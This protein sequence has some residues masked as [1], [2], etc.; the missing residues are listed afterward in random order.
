MNQSKLMTLPAKVIVLLLAMSFYGHACAQDDK[1]WEKYI[2]QMG[3]EEDIDNGRLEMLYDDLS[4]LAESKLDINTCS[5]EDLEQLPFLTKQQVMD[6]IEYRDKAKRLETPMELYLVPSLDR[7]TINLLQQFITFSPAMPSDTI[8][9]LRN[10][11]KHGK[12]ELV[13]DFN[14]P[15][16]DRKGD[17]NGYLGYKY[18]HWLRYTFNYGQRVKA[19]FTA[20]QDAGEPFFAGKNPAGYDFYSAYILLRDMRRLKALAIGR[21]RLRF[22]MGLVMN[23]SVGFGKLASLSNIWNSVNHVFGHSSRSEAKYLQGAAATIN[24]ANGLD[25]TPFVSYRKIDATLNK[26]STTVA[27]ILETGYHRT[28]SEMARR[29]NTAE[30]LAGG[31]INYFNSGFHIGATGFYSSFNRTL[32]MDNGQ[33]YRHW[34]P[35]GSSF[36]NLSV[37]YGYTSNKLNISGETATDNR[38]SVATINTISYQLNSALTMMALQRYYPYQY[39]SL[40]S[41]SFAEGGQANDESGIFVGG[42]WL[43]WHNASLM[44]YTDI[45]YFAWPKYGV[46]QSSHRWDNF[47]QL[48]YAAGKWAFLLRYRL[49]MKEVDNDGSNR[50][51]KQYNHRGRITASYSNDTWSLKTQ[52]DI[53]CCKDIANSFGYML[54]E[55]ASWKWRWF[56]A[57]ASVG[58]FH[59]D[60]YSSRVYT[61]EPGMLYNFYFHAF[62][63]HG[64]RSTL[65]ARA[66]ISDS[67]IV[68]AKLGSTHYF[69]RAQISSGL[70]QID[71]STQTDLEL[72]VKWK[73]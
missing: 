71:S 42:K 15:F 57:R 62:S 43:P 12:N 37:D 4:E 22:G 52:A 23:T 24:V 7:Q 39:F 9:S 11:L 31:N 3:E 53:S 70:Q 8:P 19:G 63:G 26:D 73:F 18:K 67:L 29:R 13:A 46:S 21:Y 1:T 69:D 30:T 17:K 45:S 72:Q 60:D 36:W 34:Y 54:S 68:I 65:N 58:Y 28:Q 10:V 48:D 49:K 59:T 44:F 20:S 56:Y 40:H 5:R 55:N 25:I 66:T 64:M 47:A 32:K 38:N 27:T 16:Y 51:I 33:R 50:L 35:D 61:Y 14:L 41:E 2:E 6:I